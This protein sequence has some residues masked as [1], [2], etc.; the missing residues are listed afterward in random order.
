MS[1]TSRPQNIP[2]YMLTYPLTSKTPQSW[3]PSVFLDVTVFRAPA[4][5]STSTRAR[6]LGVSSEPKRFF[7]N[8]PPATRVIETQT[9]RGT[10]RGSGRDTHSLRHESH[11][12][13]RKP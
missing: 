7:V 2:P 12:R 13:E 3:T 1:I 5:R 8:I 6:V 10:I 9:L 4:P 11:I